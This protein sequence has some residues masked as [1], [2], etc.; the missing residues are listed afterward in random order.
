ME[1]NERANKNSKI[2]SE[3]TIPLI[4]RNLNIRLNRLMFKLNV[5]NEI[6]EENI[7]SSEYII[8]EINE[9]IRSIEF[10]ISDTRELIRELNTRQTIRNSGTSDSDNSGDSA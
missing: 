7:R 5:L 9:R 1:L 6:K 4:L 10:E 2:P 3:I 8:N